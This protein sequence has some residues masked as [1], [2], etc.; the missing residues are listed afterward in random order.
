MIIEYFEAAA[1]GNLADSGGVE[2]VVIVTVPRLDKYS[3]VTEA[4]C[5]HLSSHVVKVNSFP[6]MSPGVL[7]CGVSVDVRELT[8]TESEN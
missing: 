5:I 2:T 7:Y 8:Q 1:G 4:L 3:R 6:D